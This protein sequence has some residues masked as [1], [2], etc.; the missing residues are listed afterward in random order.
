MRR[1]PLVLVLTI[2]L[3][4]LFFV[5]LAQ[6]PSDVRYIATDPEQVAVALTSDPPAHISSSDSLDPTLD[7]SSSVSDLE[8][9]STADV[10]S[11]SRI[12]LETS[13]DEPSESTLLNNSTVAPSQSI[14]LKTQPSCP[15]WSV[16][17]SLIEDKFSS[18]LSF[19]SA[20]QP[21]SSQTTIAF[22]IPTRS[23][24]SA[25]T[26]ESS[27]LFETF[28]P[29]LKRIIALPSKFW[30]SVYVGY[31]PGDALFDN[32]SI[33]DSFNVKIKALFADYPVSVKVCPRL[34]SS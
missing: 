18:Q 7:Y 9:N 4:V 5:L 22:L 29:E 25:H 31:D 34:I 17:R 20:P 12:P 32:S 15:N 30:F 2:A 14:T 23:L 21:D 24:P 26:V 28:F 8:P 33:W 1:L 19:S 16:P 3:G 11:E 27:S 10:P 13:F 6:S